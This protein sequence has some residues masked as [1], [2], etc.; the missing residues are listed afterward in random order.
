MLARDLAIGLSDGQRAAGRTLLCDLVAIESPSGD[1]GR[2][3]RH[4]VDWMAGHGAAAHIDAA[5]NAVGVF[6]VG[7]RQIVLLGHI[8]TFGGALPV[9][10][11]GTVLHGRGAVDAKGSLCGFAAAAAAAHERGTIPPDARVIVIGA[12]E[13][14]AASS[15]GAHHAA[16]QYAPSVCLIGEPSGWER[17]TLGYKGRLIVRWH[18][19]GGLAHSAGQAASAGDRA[20]SF[21]ALVSMWAAGRNAGEERMFGRI[22]HT[23]QAIASGH[24][25]VYGWAE[26]TIGLRLPPGAEPEAIAAEVMA[27]A[28]HDETVTCSAHERAIAAERDTPLTRALRGAIRAH[29]GTPAFVHKTGTSDMNIVGRAWAC[30]IA[31]YGAGDSALDHTPEERIDLNEYDRAVSVLADAL[32]RL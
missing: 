8:D 12:V 6:G 11:E 15:K 29:G 32:A 27:L 13:E 4:L 24:D 22:D 3:V 2:A 31:A 17:I 26:V 16:G 7:E 5:G 1:E 21:C 18:W 14:E 28:S 30:P 20:V 9:R 19:Q 10:L 23:V 25:G